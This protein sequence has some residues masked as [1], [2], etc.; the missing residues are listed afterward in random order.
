MGDVDSD[1]ATFQAVGN[2]YGSAAAAKW[3]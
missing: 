2:S 3:V 1:P